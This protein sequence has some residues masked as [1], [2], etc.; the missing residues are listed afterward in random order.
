MEK[1]C[2]TKIDKNSFVILIKI[3]RSKKNPVDA[4]P[5][6]LDKEKKLFSQFISLNS[7]QCF[8]PYK[9]MSLRPPVTHGG[10][11]VNVQSVWITYNM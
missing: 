8:K 9:Q 10:T 6:C 1:K 7:I 11:I 3:P 2:M 5:I 4:L